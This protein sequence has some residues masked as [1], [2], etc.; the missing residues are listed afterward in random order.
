MQQTAHSALCWSFSNFLASGINNWQWDVAILQ[1][2]QFADVGIN[3]RNFNIMPTRLAPFLQML[4]AWVVNLSCSS[5]EMLRSFSSGF[6]TT[7]K[8]KCTQHF[9]FQFLILL[10]W[11]K[12]YGL[13]LE[14]LPF[15]KFLS[16]HWDAL[17]LSSFKICSTS[18]II[19][20]ACDNFID[21]H[22][23]T[24]IMFS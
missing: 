19:S 14:K 10:F 17:F 12:A 15:K 21:G 24:W 11:A 23:R 18:F 7:L 8:Y 9:D 6:C 13:T 2:W 5:T 16:Y 3:F 1:I 20:A 22:R 4:L